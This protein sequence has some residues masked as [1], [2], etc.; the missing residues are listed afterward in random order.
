MKILLAS[1]IHHDVLE[2]L[3]RH[4][5]V[6]R[7]FHASNDELR[8]LVR[9]REVLVFRSGVTISSDVIDSGSK[10]GLL[11]RAGSGLDNIDVERARARQIRVVRIPGP[12]AQAVAELTFA[13]TFSLVRNVTLADRLLRDGRWPK[14]QLGGIL[15]NGK[16]L[17]VVGAGNIG[18]RVGE[19]GVA[20]GMNVL[21]CVE[22]PSAERAAALRQKGITLADFDS[23][24]GDAHIVSVHVPLNE[25]TRHLIDARVLARMQAGAFLVN[26]ARGGVVDERA[27]HAALVDGRLTGA[28]L[29]VHE[30]EGEGTI[31]PLSELSNVV[32][33]PHIGAMALDSQLEIGNRVIEFIDSFA[34][35]RIDSVALDGE[36]V[37]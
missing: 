35:G 30:R 11:I 16:T 8:A 29:D 22:H 27:L 21:G 5:E 2:Q 13:L 6:E 23:V 3:D 33:T 25:A 20:L 7:A 37:V 12:S 26:A 36:L 19:L 15:L 28:A 17:G 9:D 24:V 31:S 14:P 10:L 4:H 34:E 1:P 18:T 32:L